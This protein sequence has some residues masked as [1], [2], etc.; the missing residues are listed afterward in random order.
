MTEKYIYS[1]II[2]YLLGSIPTAYLLLKKTKGLDITKEGTGNVGARNSFDVTNSKSIGITVLIID[3]LK[4][5]AAVMLTKLLFGEVFLYGMIALNFRCFKSLL[6]PLVKVQRWKRTRHSSRRITCAGSFNFN[7][8][9]CNLGSC[10]YLPEEYTFR[11]YCRYFS[12]GRCHA[13]IF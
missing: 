10:I 4:G 1:A 6:F 7:S 13:Y 2:G 9:A 5:L 12:D 3:L 11:K 8:L